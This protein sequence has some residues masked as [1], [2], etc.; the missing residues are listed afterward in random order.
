MKSEVSPDQHAHSL[1]AIASLDVGMGGVRRGD[2]QGGDDL[3]R[4]LWQI[5]VSKQFAYGNANS[6]FYFS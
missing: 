5:Y 6:R 4:W 3:A 1:T 2:T